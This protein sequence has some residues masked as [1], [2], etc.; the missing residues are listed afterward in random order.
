MTFTRNLRKRL[1]NGFLRW[2][3]DMALKSDYA[4]VERLRKILLGLTRTTIPLRNRL[5]RNM[6]LAGVYQPHLINAHFERVVDQ[7]IMLAHV[8]RAGFPQSGC[9][10]KF[11]FD[12]SF[13]LLEQAYAKGKG[14]VCIAPHI[15]GYPVYPPIVTPRIPCAIYLRQNKD[16][17][18][19]KITQALGDA[20]DGELIYPSE[21]ATRAQR[22]QIALDVLK[23]GRMLFICAD[24]PRKPHQGVPV[25]IFGR[26]A[27]FP[28]GVFIMSL[29]TGAPVVPVT[30]HWREGQYHIHYDEPI[31]LSRGGNLKTKA[32]AAVQKWAEGVD[33]YLHQYPEMWWNWL[34]KRWTRII[35][36]GKHLETK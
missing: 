9:S 8:L 14:L 13:K 34:D 24:T 7:I 18:K 28:T 3:Q 27:Y 21:G 26:T 22:L 32:M 36:N 16:P 5:Q 10:E 31:E 19:M 29:R 12:D 35:R 23:E 33:S 1:T 30:W 25:T 17:H 4:G 6:K 15:C 20:G 2:G 11:A